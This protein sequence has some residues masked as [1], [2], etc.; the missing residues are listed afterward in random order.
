M[1]SG[2]TARHAGGRLTAP[3]M[4]AHLTES[5]R[6]AMG[7][8][9][10]PAHPAFG[11]ATVQCA[12]REALTTAWRNRTPKRLAAQLP[13]EEPDLGGIVPPNQRR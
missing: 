7:E 3:Q 12:V 2:L 6:M 10:W 1:C 5:L 4:L 9:A 11:P 8:S 13:L